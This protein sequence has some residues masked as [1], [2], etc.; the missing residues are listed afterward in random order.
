MKA[1]LRLQKFCA[2]TGEIKEVFG[3]KSS[4]GRGLQQRRVARQRRMEPGIP[5]G[6]EH[7]SRQR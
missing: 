7:V 4:I 1:K 6:H 3:G 2:R 5:A